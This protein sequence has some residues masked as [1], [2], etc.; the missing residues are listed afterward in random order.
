MKKIKRQRSLKDLTTFGVGGPANYF[1]EVDSI[2]LMQKVLPYCKENHLPYFI[3]GKGSNLI[4]DDQGF[5]G[6]VI[7]NRIQFLNKI[8][9]DIWHVGAGYSFS[10]LGSQTARQGWAGLE[11]ASGIPG[12]V[13]GAIY[14]NAGANGNEASQTLIS[15]DFITE[16]GEFLTL[17]KNEL[18]FGYRFSSFQ[19]IRGA[20]VGA[21]FRLKK[22]DEA[23]RKQLNIIQYRK[24]TQ[25]YNVKSAGCVFR[26]PPCAYAGELIEQSGLKGK[27]I[28]DAQVSTLHANFV[29]NIGHAS[30]NDILKLIQHIR[31]EVKT[32]TGFD[33]EQEV[34]YIPYCPLKK[35]IN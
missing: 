17:P 8:E 1:I 30:S 33:L 12:S 16:E 4:F 34:Y 18:A 22:T 19:Q 13:G 9:E 14:M 25:P 29:V 11:F 15:V 21:T 3:L 20:I 32:Q 26:N 35:E 23:R 5:A 28:G 2:S 7:A 6:F 24:N 27:T 10:L 31:K